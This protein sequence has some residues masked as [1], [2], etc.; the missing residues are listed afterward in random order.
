MSSDDLRRIA[1]AAAAVLASAAVSAQAADLCLDQTF[2]CNGFEPNWQFTTTV[3]SA[4]NSVVSFI[5]PE[6]PN[7]ETEPLVV[8][9]CLLQGS[10]ND[11]EV[12]TDAPLSLVANIV[13]QSC[14]EPNDDVTDFSVT[15]TF[16]QGALGANPAQVEGTGCC[17]IL[18]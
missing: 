5:D 4:G 15:V 2:K 9:G 6:N 16:V 18:P 14:V 7:W 13:G 8:G 3:D 12:T 10:P 17:T 1:V 11:F